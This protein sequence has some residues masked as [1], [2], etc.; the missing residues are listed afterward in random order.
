MNSM[1][2]RKD[3]VDERSTPLECRS[4]A[5]SSPDPAP[6]PYSS[7]MPMYK[8]RAAMCHH[9]EGETV[10]ELTAE[11]FWSC[12]SY[13]VCVNC[14]MPNEAP[15]MSKTNGTPNSAGCFLN[16][17]LYV[18]EFSGF[19]GNVGIASTSRSRPEWAECR[20]RPKPPQTRAGV[21]MRV[22]ATARHRR[23]SLPACCCC[24]LTC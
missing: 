9:V 20:E 4:S 12:S 14:C 24:P 2:P 6:A 7:D 18:G 19:E 8:Y 21:S 13:R 15:T 22:P 10:I 11:T 5:G 1:P 23:V 3:W 16:T 17:L